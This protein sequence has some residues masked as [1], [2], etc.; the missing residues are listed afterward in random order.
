MANKTV[1]TYLLNWGTTLPV[2]QPNAKPSGT[3]A[4]A[5]ASTNTVYTQAVDVHTLDNMGLELTWTGTPTGT[6]QILGSA[7]GIN[8]YPLTFVPTLTQPA[9]AAGGY[10]VNL[11]QFPWQYLVVEYTN[12]SGSGSLTAYLTSKG[13]N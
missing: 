11:N 13:L 3:V 6:I 8:Y 10:L 9:G 5:M 12:A 1:F 7:S 4:G 2:F